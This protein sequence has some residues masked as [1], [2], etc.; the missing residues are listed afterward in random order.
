[1]GLYFNI[2]LFLPLEKINQKQIYFVGSVLE[3]E[4]SNNYKNKYLIKAKKIS[5][6]TNLDKN[7]SKIKAINIYVN[8]TKDINFE[9]GDIV[10]GFGTFY[11]G[12]SNRNYKGFNNKSYLFQ[13]KIYGSIETLKIDKGKSD[14]NIEVFFYK[15]KEAII[16]NIEKEFKGENKD[17]L[18]CILIG[19]SI[20]NDN[21]KEDFRNSNLSHILAISGM[22]V[23]YVILGINLMKIKNRKLL[24]VLELIILN[25]YL[26]LTG[27]SVSCLRACIMNSLAII[28]KL[29]H[30][31]NNIYI[32]SINTFIFL[33]L[34]NV[35]NIFNAGMWLSFLGMFGIILFSKFIYKIFIFKFKIKNLILKKIIEISSLSI[36]AQVMIFP[37]MMYFFNQVSFN[38]IISNLAT[39]FLIGP[40]IILGYIIII[41]II[42]KL[43]IIVD[44]L[45]IFENVLVGILLKITDLISQN[46]K[47]N[48]FI[49]TPNILSVFFYYLVLTWI[50]LKWKK[51]NIKIIRGILSAKKIIYY[52]KNKRVKVFVILFFLIN[53][54]LNSNFNLTKDLKINFIDVGQ[55]DCTLIITPENKKILIDGGEG[56]GDKYDYGKNV[57]FPY[58]L[59]RKINKIDYLFI[60]HFDSDHVRRT[61]IY[62]RTYEGKKCSYRNSI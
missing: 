20:R 56:N 16:K 43:N 1:M 7:I 60:S 37:I 28:S 18:L 54:I 62:I 42:L 3:R 50:I 47:F 13:R 53:F 22:H 26:I 4:T 29:L 9:V 14:T 15:I 12:E 55:G 51:Q 21:I 36:S 8:T 61:N 6:Y 25:L 10:E 57:V 40:I 5:D 17:F 59:D 41:L 45:K 34:Y 32:T 31:K 35:Y 19:K 11:V 48:F 30:R 39:F 2:A 27:N 52:L 33:N 23:S 24:L 58:L 46:L 38:F 49:V 44:L